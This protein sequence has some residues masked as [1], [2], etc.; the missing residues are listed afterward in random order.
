MDFSL[1][2]EITALT[3]T[4]KNVTKVSTS[5]HLSLLSKTSD[6]LVPWSLLLFA[7]YLLSFLSL[8]LTC[9][10]SIVS[11]PNTLNLLKHVCHTQAVR[12]VFF[13]LLFLEIVNLQVDKRQLLQ[14]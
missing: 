5:F 3:R 11:L 7:H 1:G 4:C 2:I 12:G 14:N 6:S 10:S 8:A 9:S 13:F